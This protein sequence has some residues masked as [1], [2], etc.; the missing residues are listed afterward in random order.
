MFKV[1]R[2]WVDFK[3]TMYCFGVEAGRLGHSLCRTPGRSAQEKFDPFGSE[4][5]QDRIDYGGFPDAVAIMQDEHDLANDLLFD[6][7][8]RD[9]FGPDYSDLFYLPETVRLGL[10][11][12]EDF[13]TESLNQILCVDRPNTPDYAGAE[14]FLDTI[15]RRR[16]RGF[17]KF[18][19]ELQLMS[20][21][22]DLLARRGDPFTCGN[23]RRVANDSNKIATPSRLDP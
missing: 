16:G 7:C 5:F 15:N 14:I 11:N 4:Y 23:R 19:A 6:P 21:I 12:V 2:F 1:A 17:Q 8:I 3:K 20:M 18:C 22:I 13:L 9:S 10:N